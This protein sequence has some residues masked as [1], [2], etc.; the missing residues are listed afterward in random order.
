MPKHS[1]SVAKS[2]PRKIGR[3]TGL[4]SEK[5]KTICG[6]VHAGTTPNRAA[7]LAGIPAPRWCEWKA[8]AADGR[9]PYATLIAQVWAAEAVALAECEARIRAAGAGGE[10][11][12]DAWLLERRDRATYSQRLEV[13]AGPADVD[14]A[15]LSDADLE[16]IIASGRLAAPPGADGAGGEG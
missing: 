8:W 7:V 16:R 1:R 15:E 10:W 6:F 4:T 2:E 5:V 9:E 11:K 12:A 3:P 13:R 14:P